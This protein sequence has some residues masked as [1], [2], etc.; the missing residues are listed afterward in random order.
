MTCRGGAEMNTT[1][2]DFYR[3]IQREESR[4]RDPARIDT[5]PMADQN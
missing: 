4:T 1:R 5:G 3:A 2:G